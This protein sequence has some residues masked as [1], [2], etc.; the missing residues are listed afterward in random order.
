MNEDN[1]EDLDLSGVT[2]SL[3][4]Q[5]ARIKAVERWL[6]LHMDTESAQEIADA[7]TEENTA[8]WAMDRIVDFLTYEQA[9]EFTEVLEERIAAYSKHLDN[10]LP[11]QFAVANACAEERF[12]AFLKVNPLEILP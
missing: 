3:S 10:P 6:C 11:I 9:E 2:Q 4:T 5:T 7:L 1:N 8:L 12:E